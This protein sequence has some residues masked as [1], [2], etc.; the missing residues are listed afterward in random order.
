MKLDNKGIAITSMLYIILVLAIILITATLGMLSSRKLLLDNIKKQVDLENIDN[1]IDEIEIGDYIAYNSLEKGNIVVTTPN[2]IGTQTNTISENPTWRVLKKTSN[3]EILITTETSVTNTKPNWPYSYYLKG[4][5]A[6]LNGV[7]YLNTV[8]KEFS[9]T[10]Y[11]VYEKGRSINLS[12]INEINSIS[13]PEPTTKVYTIADDG[14]VYTNNK[15]TNKTIFI[16]YN[17]SDWI[18]L[19]ETDSKRVS[20]N[21]KNEEY[22][23]LKEETEAQKVLKYSGDGTTGLSYW[24]ADTAILVYSDYI[25]YAMKRIDNGNL[26]KITLLNSYNGVEQ[27]GISG[28]RPIVTLKA[29]LKYTKD[30]SGVWQI[31]N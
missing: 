1:S 15:P 31:S 19:S 26:T 5:D 30:S 6:Y 22:Y 23:N 25:M 11:A 10:S 29:G 27:D 4:K 2:G 12:D 8:C 7:V 16:Y 17:G 20:I 28:L 14:Y 21:S 13:P 18:N 9:N 3:G 24:V